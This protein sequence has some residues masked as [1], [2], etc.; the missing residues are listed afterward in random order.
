MQWEHELISPELLGDNLADKPESI[1]NTSFM[2][3]PSK[4]ALVIKYPLVKYNEIRTVHKSLLIIPFH[5]STYQIK[6]LINSPDKIQ[7]TIDIAGSL[8]NQ[9]IPCD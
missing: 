9:S 3:S 6:I 5:H 7:N 4:I 2:D 1:E 8:R